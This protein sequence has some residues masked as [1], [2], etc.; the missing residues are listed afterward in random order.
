MAR[1]KLR[2]AWVV[3]LGRKS[4]GILEKEMQIPEDKK[5]L[6]DR[7]LYRSKTWD[8]EIFETKHKGGRALDNKTTSLVFE[9][10]GNFCGGIIFYDEISAK[11]FVKYLKKNRVLKKRVFLEQEKR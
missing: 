2:D 8:F 1:R 4:R 9:E 7:T 10:S 6:V 5:W 3:Y 11:E